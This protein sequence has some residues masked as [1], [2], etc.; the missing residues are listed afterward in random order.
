MRSGGDVV[1]TIIDY[2]V[3]GGDS[4]TDENVSQ[5]RVVLQMATRVIHQMMIN[6]YPIHIFKQKQQ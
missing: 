1:V 5:K 2:N 6:N 4:M 3:V